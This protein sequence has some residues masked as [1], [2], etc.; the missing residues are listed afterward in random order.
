MTRPIISLADALKCQH[1]LEAT[2]AA[3]VLM[4]RMLGLDAMAA[5]LE[6]ATPTAREASPRHALSERS[7]PRVRMIGRQMVPPGGG[8]KSDRTSPP[9]LWDSGPDPIRSG[10]R[11]AAGR[12]RS[13]SR[14]RLLST[15]QSALASSAS[16]TETALKPASAAAPPLAPPPLFAPIRRRGILTALVATPVNEGRLDIRQIIDATIKRRPLARLPRQVR[17]TVRRGVRLLVDRADSLVLF[18]TDQDELIDRL[19]ELLGKGRLEVLEF[20]AFPGQAKTQ[21]QTHAD[22][23]D[24]DL[25]VGL[26]RWRTQRPATPVLIVSDFSIGT[27]ADHEEWIP[28]HRWC[29]FADELRARGADVV[30]LIP[31]APARWPPHLSTS[32]SCVPW[33]E[34]TTAGAVR[35][36]VRR[37]WSRSGQP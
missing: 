7:T 13:S 29:E 10:T 26:S 3:A 28:P 21:P 1:E 37:H 8:E 14:L 18:R 20:R 16:T 4:L 17:P 15:R 2:D 11:P 23:R 12:R 34:R 31:Y 35:R 25:D 33:S 5:A 6:K 27:R 22:E 36:I 24:P 32:I 9:V 30:G 19:R